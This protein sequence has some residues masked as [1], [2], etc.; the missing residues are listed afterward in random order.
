MELLTP[1]TNMLLV[2][3]AYLWAT[4]ISY[5]PVKSGMYLHSCAALT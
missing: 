4:L 3:V 5:T 2:L 1:V